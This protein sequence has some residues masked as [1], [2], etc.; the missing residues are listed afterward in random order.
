MSGAC[1]RTIGLRTRINRHDDAS[2]RCN[3]SN[4]PDQPSGSCP[5]MPPSKTPSTSGAISHPAARSASSE[6]KRSEHGETPPRPEVQRAFQTSRRRNQVDVTTPSEPFGSLML[7]S[8]I[9]ASGLRGLLG[10]F[11]RTPSQSSSSRVPGSSGFSI[12]R[13]RSNHGYWAPLGIIGA[14]STEA[15]LAGP[16]RTQRADGSRRRAPRGQRLRLTGA[17]WRLP[18]NARRFQESKA[19]Q[20]TR[21]T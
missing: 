14:S 17:L 16:R 3:D 11:S 4:R 1:A 18:A 9:E 2:A 19:T 7:S 15:A 20:I 13:R 5:F 12:G 8:S 6:T 10:L 21:E